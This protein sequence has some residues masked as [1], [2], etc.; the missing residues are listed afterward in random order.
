[1]ANRA[2]TVTELTLRIKAA[3]EEALPMGWVV[4][5]ISDF[6]RASSGHCYWTLKDETSQLSCVMFRFHAQELTFVPEPGMKLLVYGNISVYERG[7]RYQFYAY[8]LQPVGVGEMAVAVEQLRQKLE[9][10]GLFD[11]AIKKALPPFPRSVGVVTSASGAAVED[12]M[13]VVARRSP[14]VQVVLRPTRVQGVGAA[15]EIARAV[16]DLSEYSG[17]EVLIVG[18]GGGSPE[19]LWPF[20]QEIV[21][22]SIHESEIPVVSA[23]GHEIDYTIADYV[24]DVRAP[25]PSAAAELVT[26]DAAAVRDRLSDRNRRLVRAVY[27]RVGDFDSQLQDSAPER[28]LRALRLR[29]EQGEQSVD[30]LRLSLASALD[31]HL[32]GQRT[33]FGTAVIRLQAASP[34]AG[35]SRGFVFCEHLEDGRPVNHS[36]ELNPGER[37]RLRFSAGAARCLVEEVSGE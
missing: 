3:L 10:E 22:R 27:N 15:E 29:V 23:V 8:H 7:G 28:L 6:T 25:T 9:S 33:G 37:V 11:E 14:S 21:A 26:P 4:G 18:R 1:M 36:S 20:N 34:L 19:D 12:I 32:A 30:E 13:Q 5:E 31:R 2:L 16:R 35:L 17:V 24:A